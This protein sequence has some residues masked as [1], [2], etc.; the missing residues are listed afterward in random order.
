MISN[1]IG[2]APEK[3]ECDMR[4][5]VAYQ[6]IT[7][8][9]RSRSSNPL[10]RRPAMSPGALAT[11]SRSLNSQ[12]T[13]AGPM[14]ACCCQTLVRRSS[15][16]RRPTAAIRSCMWGKTDYN[17]TFGSMN[18]NKKS[19]TLDLKTEAGRAAACSSSRSAP[20]SSSKTCAPAP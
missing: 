14:R 18:R 16:S 7:D 19:V 12:A 15:R 8:R 9:L 11:A 17:G 3:V 10:R 2:I 6:P 1:V 20:M 5:E 4:V 13:S